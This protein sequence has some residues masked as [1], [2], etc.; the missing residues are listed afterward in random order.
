MFY[1]NKYSKEE[2]AN[3][4]RNTANKWKV[5]M[6]EVKIEWNVNEIVEAIAN[7]GTLMSFSFKSI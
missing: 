7:M 6:P 1:K 3:E 5:I 4:G 2:N